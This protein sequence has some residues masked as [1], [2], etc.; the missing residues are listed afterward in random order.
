MRKSRFILQL[1]MDRDLPILRTG[2]FPFQDEP[3]VAQSCE[4]IHAKV[5]VNGVDANYRSELRGISLHEVA[6]VHQLS[7]DASIDRRG[8]VREFKI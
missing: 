4:F 3:L 7:A 2:K 6:D 1:Q 8:N 5:C